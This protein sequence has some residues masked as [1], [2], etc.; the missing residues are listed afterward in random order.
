MTTP[1]KNEVTLL[2]HAN[3]LSLDPEFYD[4]VCSNLQLLRH[5]AQLVE[6]MP[7]PDRIEPACEY[8]P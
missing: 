1:T 4:G 2:A 7:L 5:Y 3:N 6:D 8:T